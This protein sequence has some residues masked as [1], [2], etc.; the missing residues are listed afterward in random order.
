MISNYIRPQTEIYQILENTANPLL[1]RIHAVV[2]GPA[3]I[4]ADKEADNIN[5]AAYQQD[6]AVPYTLVRDGLTVTKGVEALDTPSVQLLAKD[7]RLQLFTENTSVDTSRFEALP[8]DP[9]GNVLQYVAALE[10]L[11]TEDV[12]AAYEFDGGRPPTPGDIYQITD[13]LN[14]IERRVVSILGKDVGPA[15]SYSSYF[16]STP[17]TLSTAAE[18]LATTVSSNFTVVSAITGNGTTAY[19]DPELR[20]IRRYGKPG[21]SDTGGLRLVAAVTVVHGGFAY[22]TPVTATINGV[23]VTASALPGSPN[24]AIFTLGGAVQF[25]VD[26]GGAWEDGDRFTLNL[27]YATTEVIFPDPEFFTDAF[28]VSGYTYADSLRRVASNITLEV[29]EI[30]DADVMTIRV[31]DTAGQLTPTTFTTIGSVFSVT[32]DYDG[33]QIVLSSAGGAAPERFHV[34]QKFVYQMLPPSRST[35]QFDKVQLNAAIG[36]ALAPELLITAFTQFTGPLP[37][38]EPISLA[39]NYTV[40]ETQVEVATLQA[41]VAGY[42]VPGNSVRSAVDGLGT[43]GIEWR[44]AITSG[45]SDGLVPIDA[46]TDIT[47]AYQSAGLGSELGYGLAL[48][49]NGSQGKRVYGLNT[50]G[51]TV[52]DFAAAF[53]KLESANY[54]YTVAVLTSDEEVMKLASA[55]CQAMSMPTVKRFRR[56][57]VGTDSPGEYPILDMQEDTSPYT[58]SVDQGI[59]G[60]YNLVAFQDEVVFA[61]YTFTRGD[62]LELTGSGERYLIDTVDEITL[63]GGVPSIAVTL[64][65]DV[66]FPITATSVKIIA[67]D[68]AANTGRYVWKRSARIGQGVEQDRR[69]SNIW[70]D[71]GTRD[72]VTIPN[73]FGA[74]EI[75]GLRTALQPQQGLTRTEVTFIDACPTMYTKFKQSVLDEMAANGVWII[76]QNSAEG[77]CYIR[78]QLT[79][80]V[81]N[82]SLYYEDNAGTNVDTVCFALDDIV[83]PLIGKRNATARTVLEIRSKASAMLTSLTKESYDSIVGPQLVSFFNSN[84]DTDSMDV[85][86]DPNFKDRVN[87]VVG[88]EIPLPLNNVRIYVKARTI[89]DDGLIVNSVSV[90]VA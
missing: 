61:T 51:S 83:D 17:W 77:S 4:H 26:R 84:G 44:A 25:V 12:G 23:P 47:D 78:H 33:G 43:V 41:A 18:D 54:I 59:G 16:G 60:L 63:P 34:G 71:D 53:E 1:D 39:T 28:N 21:L 75:A 79:T 70:Q 85:T 5:Y 36:S 74:C 72:S 87:M 42:T 48:A 10:F 35:T 8:S 52:A 40:T 62:Y 22:P 82:G 86:I 65:Q 67:A 45:D 6:T 13:G 3:Y 80:A 19:T 46:L 11:D 55:H 81:S 73:R 7:L 89:K 20:Y 58:A 15:L 29:T 50:G 38:I 57:Y 30:S 9:F 49:F 32:M 69:I 27:D 90:T 14:T 37:A 88:I 66:G 31:T 56:C 64:Q 68:T 76:A 24:Q 2:V